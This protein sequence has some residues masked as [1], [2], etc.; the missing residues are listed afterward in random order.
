MS[1]FSPLVNS[2]QISRLFST[3]FLAETDDIPGSAA[4]PIFRS[5]VPPV[6]FEPPPLRLTANMQSLESIWSSERSA[7]R[8][9]PWSGM[10]SVSS[11][12][13][14]S[15]V[16]NCSTAAPSPAAQARCAGQRASRGE[17][18]GVLHSAPPGW[19][20]CAGGGEHGTRRTQVTRTSARQS[21]AR[22]AHPR[23]F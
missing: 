7:S 23:D 21:A 6:G 3:Q 9:D 14:S 20:G 2:Q 16:S 18:A 11:S 8:L 13:N 10:L 19:A 22:A 5:S 12:T 4:V 1:N 15:P 17:R